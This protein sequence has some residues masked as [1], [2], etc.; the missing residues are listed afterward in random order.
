[1]LKIIDRGYI[2][3]KGQV[4]VEGPSDFLA[5]DPKAREIYLGPEFNM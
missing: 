4:L 2:I 3:Y 1:M 5:N